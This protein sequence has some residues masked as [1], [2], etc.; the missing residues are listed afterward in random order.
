MTD[1]HN[2]GTDFLVKPTISSRSVRRLQSVATIVDSERFKLLDEVIKLSGYIALSKPTPG[3][4]RKIIESAGNQIGSVQFIKRSDGSLRKMSYRLHVTNPSVAK[5][6]SGTDR[7]RKNTDR[8]NNQIT[9]FDVNKSVRG[10]D[11]GVIGRGAWRTI[12]LENVT[13]IVAGGK[14]YLILPRG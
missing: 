13:R 1:A 3:E 8:A 10:K 9:V 11:G 7:Y 2:A 4:V 6:P 12:A 5:K 14:K